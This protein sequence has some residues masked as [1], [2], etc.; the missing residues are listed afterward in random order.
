MP[1]DK[2]SDALDKIP[3]GPVGFGGQGKVAGMIADVLRD[4]YGSYMPTQPSDVEIQE[5]QRVGNGVRYTINTTGMIRKVS[6]VRAMCEAIPGKINFATDDVNIESVE[7]INDRPLR[8][9]YQVKLLVKD[10]GR[11]NKLRR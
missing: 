5:V 2:V 3:D 1:G 6:E 8:K 4:T 11:F 9:T 7:K 10:R